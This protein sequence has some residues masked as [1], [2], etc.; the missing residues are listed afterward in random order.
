MHELDQVQSEIV[1]ADLLF[2]R[3]M[4]DYNYQALKEPQGSR[5]LP[6]WG[7]LSEAIPSVLLLRCFGALDQASFD[8]SRII[9]SSRQGRH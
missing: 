9:A 7:P 1:T 8:L 4:H 5:T 2:A 3:V 6:W